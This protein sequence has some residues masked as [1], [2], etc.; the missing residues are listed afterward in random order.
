MILVCAAMKSEADAILNF[1]P[2]KAMGEGVFRYQYHTKEILL[3]LTGVG[4]VQAAHKLTKLLA[5]YPIKKIYNIGLAGATAPFHQG[6][7]VAIDSAVYHDFD[8]SMFGYE[9]GQVPGQPFP[10][11]CDP[12]L[13]NHACEH[14][15][16]NHHQLY[17][18]DYFMTETLGK[19]V[20]VDME[21]AALYHIAQLEKK[22]ILAIKVISDII[23]MDEHLSS[24]QAFEAKD[25]AEILL[26]VFQKVVVEG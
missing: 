2:F 8:L 25:G 11:L 20:V 14:L 9:K 21:G 15:H 5:T 3:A 1:Y 12:M 7:I 6:D 23:G 24:Y 17:T 18:G 19:S 22:P 4:K 26:K 13:L 10:F 16:I